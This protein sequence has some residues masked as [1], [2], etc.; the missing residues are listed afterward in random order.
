MYIYIYPHTLRQSNMACCLL[1]NP[2]SIDDFPARNLH[3]SMISQL[4]TFEYRR[5]DICF[6]YVLATYQ[7]VPSCLSNVELQIIHHEKIVGI[8]FARFC[9]YPLGNHQP[10]TSDYLLNHRKAIGKP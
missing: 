1:E 5:V 6:I 7:V 8:S 4:V 10:P 2:P 3:L 9:Q